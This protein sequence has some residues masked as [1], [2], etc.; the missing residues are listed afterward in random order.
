MNNNNDNKMDRRK[1]MNNATGAIIGLSALGL[2]LKETLAQARLTG[3]PMLTEES[4][5]GIFSASN[6]RS[7]TSALAEAK[8]DV[9][10]FIRKKFT[11]TPSQE[12]GLDSLSKSQLD[13]MTSLCDA[14]EK[15]GNGLFVKFTKPDQAARAQCPPITFSF[16]FNFNAS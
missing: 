8:Q 13:S 1:F 6:Q 7:A 3:K 16:N 11:L 12:K 15:S 5:N 9:K 10:G 14:A 4:L 2:G